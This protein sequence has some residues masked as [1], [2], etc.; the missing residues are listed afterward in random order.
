[1]FHAGG[2]Q[3]ASLISSVLPHAANAYRIA[4]WAWE[5]PDPPLD[6]VGL[7]PQ[8]RRNLDTRAR[9]PERAWRG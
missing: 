7:R 3:T 9:F 2:P 1:M 5:L 8:C 6:W 4:Y